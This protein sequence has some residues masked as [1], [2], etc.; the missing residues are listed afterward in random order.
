[1]KRSSE[2]LSVLQ[3]YETHVQFYTPRRNIYIKTCCEA[4]RSVIDHMAL[5]DNFLHKPVII[6]Y[7]I[8]DILQTL[9]NYI[10]KKKKL[11]KTRCWILNINHRDISRPEQ[12]TACF[13]LWQN[14]GNMH[15]VNSQQLLKPNKARG[16]LN[17]TGE[18]A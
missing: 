15:D 9:L 4:T 14:N 2:I 12:L 11:T 18:M 3:N 17:I 5:S 1:M 16:M 8:Q 6:K 13:C 10:K 7:I